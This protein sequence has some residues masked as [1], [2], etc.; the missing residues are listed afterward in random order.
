MGVRKVKRKDPNTGIVREFYMID[1]VFKHLD[2]Y[3]ERV[4]EVPDIQTKQGAIERERELFQAVKEG[5][6]GKRAKQRVGPAPRLRD[7]APRYLAAAAASLKPSS[8]ADKKQRMEK[9]VLPNFGD[10]RL[11]EIG[12]LEI[13]AYRAKLKA[14]GLKATSINN[15]LGALGSV[16]RYAVETKKLTEAPP[17]EFDFLDFEEYAQLLEVAAREPVWYAAVLLAGDA[18][19]RLG[20]IMGL[21]L[22][23]ATGRK[24]T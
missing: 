7:F 1:F 20:E 11:D 3:R 21:H 15:S 10:K 4:R 14:A 23:D 24:P 13:D 2:G 18:G 19:L 22:T 6:Y 9:W 12:V 5:I 8:L 16:L 17:S